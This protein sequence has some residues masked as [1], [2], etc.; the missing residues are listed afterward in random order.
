MADLDDAGKRI[1]TLGCGL[2]LVL[3]V[4][5]LG[6]IFF[7]LFGLVVG[8]GIALLFGVGMVKQAFEKKPDG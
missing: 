7:G 4:P 1:Q 2:T 3:T 8:A 5:I 6:L